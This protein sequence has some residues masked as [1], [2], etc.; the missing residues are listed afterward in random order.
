M[1]EMEEQLHR[2]SSSQKSSLEEQLHRQWLCEWDRIE[3]EIKYCQ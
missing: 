2:Q 3:S 1:G